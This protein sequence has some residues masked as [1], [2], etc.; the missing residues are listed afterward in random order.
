MIVSRREQAYLDQLRTECEVQGL[1]GE[2]TNDIGGVSS[3][4]SKNALLAVC[5]REGIANTLVRRSETT[6]LDLRM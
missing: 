4:E 3:P 2:I 5:A 6:L 1:G